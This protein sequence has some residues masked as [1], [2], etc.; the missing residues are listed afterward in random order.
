MIE[1]AGSDLQ[2]CGADEYADTLDIEEYYWGA[3]END[4]NIK[5]PQEFEQYPS[6]LAHAR[7]FFERVTFCF[8]RYLRSKFW[9]KNF[10]KNASTIWRNAKTMII[11]RLKLYHDS[12]P[13]ELKKHHF[14]S[15]GTCK[16]NYIDEFECNTIHNLRQAQH[17]SNKRLI[18]G[19][20]MIVYKFDYVEAICKLRNNHQMH[21]IRN[22]V[23]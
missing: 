9:I 7:P 17:V 16:S 4:H 6:Q 14:H 12:E 11:D 20:W 13:N 21:S 19:F 1:E 2:L 8:I 22:D 10:V 23:L 3:I 15:I 18:K 5:R